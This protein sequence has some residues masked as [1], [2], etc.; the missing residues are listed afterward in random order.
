MQARVRDDDTIA[1]GESHQF[2]MVQ[3]QVVFDAALPLLPRQAPGTPVSYEHVAARLRLQLQRVLGGDW[4]C[5]VGRQDGSEACCVSWYVPSVRSLCFRVHNQHV[6]L[7]A[8]VHQP[9]PA[10]A[11]SPSQP[12]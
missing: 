9:R 2:S 3:K 12:A 6:V 1:E 10:A 8:Q 11:L 7:A 5:V 4:M